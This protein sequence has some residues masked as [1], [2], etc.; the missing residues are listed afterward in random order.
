MA[1]PS[2]ARGEIK[3]ADSDPPMPIPRSASDQ[4]EPERKTREFAGEFVFVAV[5]GRASVK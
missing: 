1:L 3:S 4:M 5:I 2:L